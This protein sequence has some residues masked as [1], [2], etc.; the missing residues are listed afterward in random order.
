MENWQRCHF[1]LGERVHLSLVSSLLH[2]LINVS[3]SL[4][5]VVSTYFE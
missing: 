3:Q 2:F 5:P 1:L 4:V